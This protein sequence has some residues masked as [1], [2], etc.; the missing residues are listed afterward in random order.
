MSNALVARPARKRSAT[1]SLLSIVLALDALLVFF[2]M[3]AVFGLR[4][5][6]PAATLGGGVALIVVFALAG[7]FVSRPWG[8]WFGHALQ[9]VLIALGL[10][11]APMYV[12]GIIFALLWAY[13][14][15]AGRRL[16]RRNARITASHLFPPIPEENS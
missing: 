3:L 13:C 15:L 1:E 12:I 5:L 14:F 7:R 10:I 4:L 9:L 6:P 8:V 2:V 11:L 16:D